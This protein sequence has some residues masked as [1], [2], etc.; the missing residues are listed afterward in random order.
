M[1][2][3][4]IAMLIASYLV[5]VLYLIVGSCRGRRIHELFAAFYIGV[6]AL[7]LSLLL[8]IFAVFIDGGF[9]ATAVLV[10]DVLL[11]AL[12]VISLVWRS[13]KIAAVRGAYLKIE[14]TDSPSEG[15]SENF[16]ESDIKDETIADKDTKS[17]KCVL[18]KNNGDSLP[19]KYRSGVKSDSV[20]SPNWYLWIFTI[21]Y[22]LS[23]NTLTV[24][25]KSSG[26]FSPWTDIFTPWS[27]ATL[28]RNAKA[29]ASGAAS[30]I[31]NNKD[32]CVATGISGKSSDTDHEYSAAVVINVK[33][34]AHGNKNIINLEAEAATAVAG[35]VA[36]QSI[37]ITAG[38]GSNAPVQV[39][40]QFTINVPKGANDSHSNG[41]AVQFRCD[42]V[43]T[44]QGAQ[45]V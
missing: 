30:C 35:Q 32:E 4:S 39:S 38:T 12:I 44:K 21:N 14:S 29:I 34:D 13:V 10:L 27:A 36:I 24:E 1:T 5:P 33:K 7:G 15:N 11:S 37:Q 45:A 22:Q 41:G 26:T 23:G 25:A 20:L 3:Y 8:A 42:K 17:C 40:G 19:K 43:C 28:K 2:N 18:V 31:K 16:E 9:A 6:A